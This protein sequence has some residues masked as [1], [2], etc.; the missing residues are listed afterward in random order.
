MDETCTYKES[1]LP[2]GNRIIESCIPAEFKFPIDKKS[3]FYRALEIGTDNGND[4]IASDYRALVVLQ[5]D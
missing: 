4:Y 2:N 5:K 1:K 3:L